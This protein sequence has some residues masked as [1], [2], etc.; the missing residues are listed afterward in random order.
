MLRTASESPRL[1]VWLAYAVLA[2][3]AIVTGYATLQDALGVNPLETLIREP[4]KWA[5]TW[6]LAA[7][8]IAPLRHVFMAIA[9]WRHWNYGKRLSDWN[10][11]IRLRRPAG[12]ASFFYAAVH[13]AVYVSL[14]LEFRWREFVGDLDDKPYIAV[15]VATFVLLFPLAVTST[16]AWM[17]LLKRNWKRLHL[18]IYPA[19]V[20]AEIHFILLSKPGVTD[21]LEYG[22]VLIGLLGYRV[23]QSRLHGAASQEHIDGTAPER[24]VKQEANTSGNLS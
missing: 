6:L 5:L 16:N 7:L 12:L 11:L 14:D 8:A 3:P 9:I 13:V 22:L 1:V 15:G 10:W 24:P 4:G 19:A 21:Y 17:R 23:V 18:L 20:L 2:A